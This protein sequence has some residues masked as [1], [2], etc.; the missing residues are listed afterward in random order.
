MLHHLNI[1]EDKSIGIESYY[2]LVSA[3]KF[4][5]DLPGKDLGL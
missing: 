2:S 3:L 5:R 4:I 1:R